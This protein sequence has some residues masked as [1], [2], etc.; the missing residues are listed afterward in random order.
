MARKGRPKRSQI[1]AKMNSMQA[2]G[3]PRVEPPIRHRNA[4]ETPRFWCPVCGMCADLERLLTGPYEVRS[5]VQLYG[6][7]REDG[8]GYI[9]YLYDDD[10][11]LQEALRLLE[12]QILAALE[13]VRSEL[14]Y[15][16]EDTRPGRR[17]PSRPLDLEE[18]DDL[19]GE[20]DDLLAEVD[21]LLDEEDALY[22]PAPRKAPKRPKKSKQAAIRAPKRSKKSKQAAI[23]GP[24][25]QEYLRLDSGRPPEARQNQL[26]LPP[27]QTKKP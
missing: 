10:A 12:P 2:L 15:P 3:L 11:V 21:D 17:S 5:A 8:R 13:V 25:N 18:E 23:R 9:E 20:V 7:R 4:N 16:L 19:L 22:L 14:G 24:E 1:E 26:R 27:G 6:G